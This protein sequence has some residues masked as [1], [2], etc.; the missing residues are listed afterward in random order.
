MPILDPVGRGSFG[1]GAPGEVVS[2]EA[3]VVAEVGDVGVGVV[4]VEPDSVA[5]TRA[6][7]AA[8]RSGTSDSC[9]MMLR[10]CSQARKERTVIVKVDWEGYAPNTLR[11]S[12]GVVT[13]WQGVAVEI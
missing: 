2:D 8:A 1:G 6:T 11:T 3:D 7:P 13:E 9:H 12:V 10:S 5:L 4:D